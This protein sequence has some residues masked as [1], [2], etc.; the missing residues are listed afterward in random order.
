MN[1]P[2]GEVRDVA[3]R[4]RRRRTEGELAWQ[5]WSSVARSEERSERYIENTRGPRMTT[6]ES[7]LPLRTFLGVP[8]C[9]V[10]RTSRYVCHAPVRGVRALPA[11]GLGERSEESR[12]A[13]GAQGGDLRTAVSRELGPRAPRARGA[14]TPHAPRASYCALRAPCALAWCARPRRAAERGRGARETTQR[15]SR[16]T[17]ERPTGTRNTDDLPKINKCFERRFETPSK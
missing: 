1:W 2:G 16:A 13:R 10:C 14:Q 7:G 5:R 3:L 6:K 4:V 11:G 8:A 17:T 12:S 15:E 9:R